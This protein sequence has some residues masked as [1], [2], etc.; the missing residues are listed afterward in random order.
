MHLVCSFVLGCEIQL[1]DIVS[2]GNF[3]K[4]KLSIETNLISYQHFLPYVC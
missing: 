3:V 2:R 1:M 4:C